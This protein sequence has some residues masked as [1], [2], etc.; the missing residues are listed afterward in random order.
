MG[1]GQLQGPGPSS[2]AVYDLYAW[3]KPHCWSA[4]QSKGTLTSRKVAMVSTE[5]LSFMERVGGLYKVVCTKC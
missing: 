1:H 5:T 3:C 2:P 4:N